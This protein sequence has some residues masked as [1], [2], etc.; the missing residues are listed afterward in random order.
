MSTNIEYKP[1]K[2][3]TKQCALLLYIT[4]IP[5]YFDGISAATN[6]LPC[7]LDVADAESPDY[8]D[9]YRRVYCR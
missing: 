6:S 7:W 1:I 8:I 2:Y 3:G 5:S 9:C 4:Q